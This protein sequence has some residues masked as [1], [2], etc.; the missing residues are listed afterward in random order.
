MTIEP[1]AV[2]FTFGTSVRTWNA[3]DKPPQPIIAKLFRDMGDSDEGLTPAVEDIAGKIMLRR[4]EIERGGDQKQQPRRT[5]AA[6]LEKPKKRTRGRKITDLQRQIL[7]YLRLRANVRTSKI[8]KDLGIA[9]R[10]T[11]EACD[12]IR[13]RRGITSTPAVQCYEVKWTITPAGLEALENGVW[14]YD[15]GQA[16]EQDGTQCP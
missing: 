13:N 6:L 10:E 12:R 15:V 7:N 5:F 16:P 1:S 3:D 11:L 14:L 9:K 4:A 2:R 8:A